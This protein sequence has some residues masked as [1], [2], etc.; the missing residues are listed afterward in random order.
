MHKTAV[1]KK[2]KSLIDVTHAEKHKLG[3]QKQT[4]EEFV[5]MF[6]SSATCEPPNPAH[7]P[8]TSAMSESSELELQL[9]Q[10]ATK[11]C[12]CF[13]HCRD[14][15]LLPLPLLLR[16]AQL[17]NSTSRISAPSSGAGCRVTHSI[18]YLVGYKEGR[19]Y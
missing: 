17:A 5:W 6:C 2:I 8:S 7:S 9:P 15:L 10:V 11:C 16:A 13:R 14:L 18:K 4:S 3:F 19:V 12:C 1:G